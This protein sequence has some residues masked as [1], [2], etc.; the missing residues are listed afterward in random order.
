M[1]T[2]DLDHGQGIG[3]RARQAVARPIDDAMAQASAFGC[4]PLGWGSMLMRSASER[5]RSGELIVERI[6]VRLRRRLPFALSASGAMPPIAPRP[7]SASGCPG[8]GQQRCSHSSRIVALRV[9]NGLMVGGPL[10]ER[11]EIRPNVACGLQSA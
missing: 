6:V 8:R 10:D 9:P 4:R 5:T 7:P 1:P 11:M 3:N 2:L